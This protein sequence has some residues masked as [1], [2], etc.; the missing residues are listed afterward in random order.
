MRSALCRTDARQFIVDNARESLQWLRAGNQ[1]SVD[2]ES[3]RAG[4]AD[5]IAFRDIFS[6]RSLILSAIQT[7]F[8]SGSIEPRF[9]R[10][11]FKNLR[12][13]LGW[14]YEK[15][16]VISPEFALVVG[17]ARRLVRLSCSGVKTLDWKIT[18]DQLDFFTVFGL[19]LS[20]GW[21]YPPAEGT[22]PTPQ[23]QRS[24]KHKENKGKRS[25][26]YLCCASTALIFRLIVE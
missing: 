9:L 6:D 7:S 8:E 16:V 26:L 18:K 11:S 4:Y 1:P 13:T 21:K 25:G 2:E 15:L 14:R 3:R 24:K 12:T 23:A 20:E 10:Q 17:T 5:P 22:I 19:E